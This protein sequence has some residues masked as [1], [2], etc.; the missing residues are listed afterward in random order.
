MLEFV[1]PV[2]TDELSLAFCQATAPLCPDIQRLIWREVLYCTVPIEAP[3]APIKRTYLYERL[4]TRGDFYFYAHRS[5]H[6]P[7]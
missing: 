7:K 3:S 5:D 4:S 1:I 6:L 2:R